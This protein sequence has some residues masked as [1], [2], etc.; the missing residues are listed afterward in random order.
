ME[1]FRNEIKLSIDKCIFENDLFTDPNINYDKLEN[2]ITAAKDKCFPE[3]EVKFNKYKHKISPWL[4]NGILKSM[5]FR[6]KLYVKWKKSNPLS[7]MYNQ[8]EIKFKNYCSLLQKTIRLAKSS[9]YYNKFNHY[10]TD[11]KNTWKQINELIN[12]KRREMIYLNIF[13]KTNRY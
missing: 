4:T 1:A 13:L 10:K 7:T 5:K 11:M 3:K 2:I 9:Y 8:L 6:D 12:K